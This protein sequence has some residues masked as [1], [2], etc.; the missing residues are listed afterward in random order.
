MPRTTLALTSPQENF[1]PKWIVEQILKNIL[2]VKTMENFLVHP[3]GAATRNT[4]Y[5]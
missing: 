5:C 3:Q 1:L 4:I 2:L